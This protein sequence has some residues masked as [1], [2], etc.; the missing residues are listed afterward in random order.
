MTI[1]SSNE[2]QTVLSMTL[3]LASAG[4][5][6][7]SITPCSTAACELK[8]VS[9]NFDVEDPVAQVSD[10]SPLAEFRNGNVPMQIHAENLPLSHEGKTP[11]VSFFFE[12]VTVTAQAYAQDDKTGLLTA[13]FTV[14]IPSSATSRSVMLALLFPGLVLPFP[15]AFTYRPF[16][17]P[18]MTATPMLAFISTPRSIRLRVT[19]LA[20]VTSVSQVSIQLEYVHSSTVISVSAL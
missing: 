11:V 12:N 6:F 3:A 20:G 14:P 16:P 19:N 13:D 8:T 9:F 18:T 5:A 7:V 4:T 17:V 10:V 15:V 2:D 1:V